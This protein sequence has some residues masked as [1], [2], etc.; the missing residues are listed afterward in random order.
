M[1]YSYDTLSYSTKKFVDNYVYYVYSN[2]PL[3]SD[4]IINSL[5]ENFIKENEDLN[6]T[7]RFIRVIKPTRM[8][9]FIKLAKELSY[10]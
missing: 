6:E 10:L 9:D 2:A 7:Y 5:N 3:S 4:R 1:P 8:S